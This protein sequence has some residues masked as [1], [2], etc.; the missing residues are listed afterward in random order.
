MSALYF[1]CRIDWNA[2]RVGIAREYG[3]ADPDCTVPFGALVYPEGWTCGEPECGLPV[4][5]QPTYCTT[6]VGLFSGDAYWVEGAGEACACQ[7]CSGHRWTHC[8]DCGRRGDRAG[9]TNSPVPCVPLPHVESTGER[10][11]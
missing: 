9:D 4:G 1:V 5:L 6:R 10:W 2:R 3:D 8:H 11:M 7:S